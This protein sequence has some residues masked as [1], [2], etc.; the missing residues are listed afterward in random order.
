MWIIKLIT[1]TDLLWSTHREGGG[2]QAKLA[3]AAPR[4]QLVLGWQSQTVLA[5]KSKIHNPN[6]RWRNDLMVDHANKRRLWNWQRNELKCIYW[7]RALPNPKG[8]EKK[9][10]P[11]MVFSV[12]RSVSPH[13]PPVFSPH[14][15]T[16][17]CSLTAPQWKPPAATRTTTRPSR[18]PSKT[19]A[20][21]G[22]LRSFHNS[23][24]NE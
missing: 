12:L 5:S 9:K 24:P 10:V 15:Y 1:Q 13:C 19:G 17:P 7:L 3:A 18:E 8:R 2:D 4:P 11:V 16:C 22:I 23:S 6:S 20:D 14:V 21:A